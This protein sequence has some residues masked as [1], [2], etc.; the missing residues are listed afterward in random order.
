MVMG[1]IEDVSQSKLT[2]KLHLCRLPYLGNVDWV[3]TIRHVAGP[4]AAGG[5]IQRKNH[6][7]AYS[8]ITFQWGSRGR[9]GALSLLIA[10]KRKVA[11]A[12]PIPRALSAL[13]P[14][15]HILVLKGAHFS[16]DEPFQSEMLDYEKKGGSCGDSMVARTLSAIRAIF[17][18]SARRY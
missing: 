7:P 15:R 13:W 2:H 17:S 4:I 10:P 18:F 1:L 16:T 14:E 12:L 5:L 11:L 3:A 9:S 8:P 6:R